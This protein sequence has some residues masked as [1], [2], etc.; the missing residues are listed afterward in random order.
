MIS[1]KQI[2]EKLKLKALHDVE[3]FNLNFNLLIDLFGNLGYGLL[4]P[5]S[6]AHSLIRQFCVKY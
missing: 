2:A 3:N 5:N 6:R 1:G 4:W